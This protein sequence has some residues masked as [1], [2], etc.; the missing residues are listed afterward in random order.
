MKT[1][2]AVSGTNT[3]TNELRPSM[4]GLTYDQKEV[5][6][7]N[8]N[9]R[10]NSRLIVLRLLVLGILAA[11]MPTTAAAAKC[12]RGTLAEYIKLGDQGCTLGDF[13]F[14]DFQYTPKSNEDATGLPAEDITVTPETDNNKE[15]KREAVNLQFTA[16]WGV[17]PGGKIDSRISYEVLI[18]NG[19]QMDS[20]ELDMNNFSVDNKATVIVFE[21]FPGP[22]DLDVYDI[23]EQKI[24]KQSDS[25]SFPPRDFALVKTDIKLDSNGFGTAALGQ[26]D[27]TFVLLKKKKAKLDRSTSPESGASNMSYL[28]VSGSGFPEGNINPTN[29]VVELATKCHRAASGTTSAVS[30]V[31]GPG[32]SELLSFLLPGGLAP[33]Q[34]FV[35]ISDSAEGDANFESSNCSEVN[36]I[37]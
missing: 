34:Y 9:S 23:K 6:M 24:P 33:G 22:V 12:E 3:W 8:R 36:V 26:V 5:N 31:S 35:S 1:Q 17:G 18:L 10:G 15:E 32:D 14:Y 13:K 16:Q 20:I 21:Q 27:N 7:S 4:A 25:K 28:A 11:G 30:I 2:L 29:V 37:Q 19:R